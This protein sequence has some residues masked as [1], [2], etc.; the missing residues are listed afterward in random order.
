MWNYLLTVRFGGICATV[1]PR[2]MLK[3]VSLELM[4]F[5]FDIQAFLLGTAS[6]WARNE[7]PRFFACGHSVKLH[8]PQFSPKLQKILTFFL[9]FYLHSGFWDRLGTQFIRIQICLFFFVFVTY[10]NFQILINFYPFLMAILSSNFISIHPHEHFFYY[11]RARTLY[12]R[13]SSNA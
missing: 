4:K 12:L 2:Q 5:D 6:F 10:V 8:L 7:K 11:S 13:I 9:I 3:K 1:T